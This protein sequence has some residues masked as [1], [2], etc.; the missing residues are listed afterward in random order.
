MPARLF[1]LLQVPDVVV[2]ALWQHQKGK[3]APAIHA[4]GAAPAATAAAEPQ[5]QLHAIPDGHDRLEL[6]VTYAPDAEDAEGTLGSISLSCTV[7]G[8]LLRG[9]LSVTAK[10]VAAPA[11]TDSA[12]HSARSGSI[13]ARQLSARSLKP[14][15]APLPSSLKAGAPPSQ[16]TQPPAS[17]RPP[18]AASKPAPG[19]AVAAMTPPTSARRPTFHEPAADVASQSGFQS[20][21]DDGSLAD[22]LAAVSDQTLTTPRR[23]LPPQHSAP[24][25][26]TTTT[27]TTTT[28]GPPPAPHQS[29]MPLK[30]S[31]TLS[32]RS[33]SVF[34]PAARPAAGVGPAQA[35]GPPPLHRASS[36][37]STAGSMAAMTPRSL[38]RQSSV[39]LSSAQLASSL[40]GGTRHGH[41]H[42]APPT[43]QSAS[44]GR[45]ALAA[46]SSSSPG[47]AA[48]AA[49]SYMHVHTE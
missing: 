19:H 12:Q 33:G 41:H 35:G 5:Q 47:V 24:P 38:S 15:A 28:M 36:A 20:A 42:G 31:L 29:G 34:T 25:Q 22:D 46:S 39:T 40:A 9:E 43:P 6:H 48:K 1:P 13:Y 16:R 27:T 45:A 3:H 26:P 8:L 4:A 21:D 11:G 2:Q 23:P 17:G 44:K 49:R 18:A 14:P 10:A 7:G 37:S 32:S 30:R